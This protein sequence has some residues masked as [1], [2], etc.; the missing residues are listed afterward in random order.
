MTYNMRKTLAG[1]GFLLLVLAPC[2]FAADPAVNL[3][4]TIL[5]PDVATRIFGGPAEASKANSEADMKSGAAVVSRCS[6]SIKNEAGTA[7]NISLLLRRAATLDEG[8]AIFLA[9]KL[10]HH[11]E[12]ISDLGDAAYRTAAPAQLNVLKGKNWLIISAGAFP[13]PDP[14]L[15]EKAAREILKNVQD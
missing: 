5:T 13:K 6:Y 8:K 2:V 15:Q 11:D 10:T 1:T 12:E 4:A 7:T 3:A 14:I 9:S